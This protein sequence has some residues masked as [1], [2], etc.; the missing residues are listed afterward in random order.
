[1]ERALTSRSAIDQAKGVIM[2]ARQI[3]A[4]DAF[5]ALVKQSQHQNRPL[6]EVAEQF[7]ADV[8]RPQNGVNPS[9]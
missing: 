1:M 9:C 2:A 7:L 8:T 5:A 4:E 3:S 6:R